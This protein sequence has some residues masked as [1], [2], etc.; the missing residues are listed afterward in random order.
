MMESRELDWAG[1]MW[2][3][4]ERVVLVSSVDAQGRPNLIAVG[5]AMR[6]NMDPPVYA[7][8]L[9]KKSHSCANVSASGEFVFAV[10]GVDLAKAVLYC[11]THSARYGADKFAETGLTA[12][13][14]SCVRPPLVA[15]CLANLECR[16]V[17]TQDVG[18]H[19]VFFGQVV[20]C[21]ASPRQEMRPLILVGAEA[22]YE[23]AVTTEAF[24]LGAVRR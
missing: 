24:R 17:A 11:G 9:G 7:I 15:E 18:D 20:A 1:A 4:P 8:G 5:W 19:R 6:A 22:G 13:P 14:A 12:A 23:T 10:P 2:A 16:V 21:W 3:A